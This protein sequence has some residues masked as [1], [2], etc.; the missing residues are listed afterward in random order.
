MHSCGGAPTRAHPPWLPPPSHT[1]PHQL[2]PCVPHRAHS[3]PSGSPQIPPPQP[4]EVPRAGRRL[5][6]AWHSQ[7]PRHGDATS[8]SGLPTAPSHPLCVPS[9]GVTLSPPMHF[10]RA[11]QPHPP[12]NGGDAARCGAAGSQAAPVGWH[13]R[14]YGP[15]QRLQIN[16][17]PHFICFWGYKGE[18][19]Q[20][21]LC[22][23][24]P[25]LPGAGRRGQ[26]GDSETPGH[27][28][29]PSLCPGVPEGK[30]V[31]LFS[32]FLWPVNLLGG[33]RR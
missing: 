28:A 21:R 29:H 20:L 30:G 31:A 24:S 32:Y 6:P 9:R 17:K 11:P 18:L 8:G 13:R 19:T 10:D 4:S 23:R 12:S 22:N 15:A 7:S 2:Q 3:L 27:G 16:A 25:L 26:A 1:H 14:V 33:P 5:C